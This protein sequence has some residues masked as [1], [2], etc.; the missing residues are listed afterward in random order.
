MASGSPPSS[1]LCAGFAGGLRPCLTAVARAACDVS[2][3]DEETPASAE[4]RNITDAMAKRF[5]LTPFP[6]LLSWPS[7]FLAIERHPLQA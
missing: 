3:R 7:S 1:T 2:G 4:Q 6:H 5:L